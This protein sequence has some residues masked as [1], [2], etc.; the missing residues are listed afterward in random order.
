MM[1]RKI[2]IQNTGSG[3]EKRLNLIPKFG[4]THYCKNIRMQKIVMLV[5]NIQPLRKKF[6][7]SMLKN[8]VR[9]VKKFFNFLD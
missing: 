8:L 7:S 3:V 4:M 9:R 1:P 5:G 6:G 2:Q